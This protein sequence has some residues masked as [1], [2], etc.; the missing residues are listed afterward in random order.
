MNLDELKHLNPPAEPLSLYR[1]QQAERLLDT[2]LKLIQTAQNYPF[3]QASPLLQAVQVLMEALRYRQADVRCHLALAYAFNLMNR[4]DMA[5]RFVRQAAELAPDQQ[6]VADMLWIFGC[7][8]EETD[9]PDACFPEV[10]ALQQSEAQELFLR[11]ENHIIAR[12]HRLMKHPLCQLEPDASLERAQL[13]QSGLSD[14]R[15]MYLDIQQRLQHLAPHLAVEMLFQR[16][17]PLKAQLRRLQDKLAL[18]CE[19]RLLQQQLDVSMQACL[20][21]HQAFSRYLTSETLQAEID[22]LLDDCQDFSHRLDKLETENCQIQD[23]KGLYHA[24]VDQVS[25]LMERHAWQAIE[26]QQKSGHR[27]GQTRSA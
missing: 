27:P 5:Q 7:E 13:F 4:E 18:C 1:Y 23:L 11:M 8:E 10:R 16:L 26:Q 3:E 25:A 21:L 19:L 9:L 20:H 2:G 14:I 24:L 22:V 6:L 12:V 15:A 17:Q